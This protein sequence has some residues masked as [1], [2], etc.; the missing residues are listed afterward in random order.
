MP[1]AVAVANR[2]VSAT[3]ATSGLTR[4]E[5]LAEVRAVFPGLIGTDE[6][7]EMYGGLARE[8]HAIAN[9]FAS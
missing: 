1:T 6:W 5:V 3:D 2:L 9:I 4:E 7:R 8:Q